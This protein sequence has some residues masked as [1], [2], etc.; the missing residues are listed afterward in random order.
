MQIEILV[1]GLAELVARAQGSVAASQQQVAEIEGIQLETQN[2]FTGALQHAGVAEKVVICAEGLE[3]AGHVLFVGLDRFSGN[4]LVRPDNRQIDP[5]RLLAELIEWDDRLVS[6]IPEIDSQHQ[7]IVRQ[8][9]HLFQTLNQGLASETAVLYA[10]TGRLLDWIVQH[11]SYEQ[12]W[13]AKSDDPHQ[14]R[15]FAHHEKV[16]QEM[17]VLVE[18]LHSTDV[19]TAYDILRELR[20]WLVNHILD[21]DLAACAY[22]RACP[23]GKPDWLPVQVEAQVAESKIEL[24]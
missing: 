2:I 15:H 12:A 21:E 5:A 19:R 1:Q 7:E 13:L 4:G 6:G 10:A 14:K 23:Q 17:K 18:K 16:V 11:F 20:R 9:N 22:L 24:F 8:L 3:R